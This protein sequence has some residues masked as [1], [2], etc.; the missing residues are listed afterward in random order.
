[1]VFIYLFFL[2]LMQPKATVSI[3]LLNF[4]GVSSMTPNVLIN[5]FLSFSIAS[6][7]QSFSVT[8]F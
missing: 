2:M 7:C 4:L 5:I 1:M 8:T 3:L 6:L